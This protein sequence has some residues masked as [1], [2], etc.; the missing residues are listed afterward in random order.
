MEGRHSPFYYIYA[1]SRS[2]HSTVIGLFGLIGFVGVCCTPIYGRVIDRLVPWH[3]SVA[4]TVGLL[5]TFS[6]YWGAAGVTLAVPVISTLGLD[7]FRQSQ[8]ISLATRIFM[9]DDGLRSRLNACSMFSVRPLI[10]IAPRL[11]DSGRQ[12]CM[13]QAIGSAAGSKVFLGYGWRANGALMVAFGIFQLVVLLLRG[14]HTKRY[15][16]FGYEG[17]LDWRRERPVPLHDAEKASLPERQGTKDESISESEAQ[18]RAPSLDGRDKEK[19]A[20]FEDDKGPLSES[21]TRVPSP[22]QEIDEEKK[23]VAAVGHSLD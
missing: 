17:G 15:T 18:T 12:I 23:S 22:T 5:L 3:V 10:S 1:R 19:D 6:L 4:M 11:T 20:E 2:S 7:V 14:P 8:Q 21:Q 9:L 16:W 13:G